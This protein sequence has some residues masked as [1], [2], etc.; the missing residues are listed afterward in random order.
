MARA[1]LTGWGRYPI[2]D[3]RFFA[4][5]TTSSLRSCMDS[6]AGG[7]LLARGLGRSYG[8]AALS[9]SS[10]VILTGKLD[11]LLSFD[12]RNGTLTCEAGIS[13]ADLLRVFLPRGWFPS[14]TPGT[15]FVTMGGALACDIHGKNH[16]KEGSF[17]D[18][19]SSFKLLTADL[20]LINCSRQENSD[21]FWAT[22]GGM[23][24][25]G[26]ISEITLSLRPV[27][28][29]FMMVKKIRCGNLSEAFKM[30]E[31]NEAEYPYS[32]SWIDCLAG[33]KNLGR[34]ILILGR[35]AKAA[36]VV[37]KDPLDFA[38]P[39]QRLTVPF[40]LPVWMLNRYSI[41]SFNALYYTMAGGDGHER[42]SA[43][44]PFFYPLDAIGD[45]NRMYGSAGFVQHQCVLPLS[46]S[47]AGLEEIL[48]LSSK[49][50]RSSFLAVLK[51]FGSGHGS[52]SF[53]MAGY[54][55]ALDMPVKPGLF[56]FTKELD[57]LVIKHG[58]RVYLT[59]DACLSRETFRRMYPDLSKWT[60]VK[61]AVDPHNRFSSA[62]SERLQLS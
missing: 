46:T 53:P 19:V 54:T 56:E 33:G 59:K 4:P 27:E 13:Y 22:A 41:G 32:V 11:H 12:E 9:K 16:H 50:G 5:E 47:Y 48:T 38:E 26:I 40:D 3:G 25:T 43:I 42:V 21:L 61:K 51:K 24:L 60:A 2:I 29:Q 55:L 36:E 35:H 17:V 37:G 45:W 1:A 18:F 58:G 28:S 62:L 14:V 34:S 39:K 52:I 57:E 20:D 49:R 31:A 23:G 7:G 15:K 8:D 10:A 30:I 6:A 44:D